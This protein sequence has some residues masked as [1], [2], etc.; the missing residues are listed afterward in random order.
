M[1]KD[2]KHD[3]E[4]LIVDIEKEIE[5][6]SDG[7]ELNNKHW[8]FFKF[9][10]VFSTSTK[11]LIIEP[12]IIE[13]FFIAILDLLEDLETSFADCFE[14]ELYTAIEGL[15]DQVENLSSEIE[16][17]D[18]QLSAMENETKKTLL[19]RIEDLTEKVRQLD[20][21]KEGLDNSVSILKDRVS[22]DRNKIA[23]LEGTIEVKKK[24]IDR[25]VKLINEL[26]STTSKRKIR[27]NGKVRCE[28]K[29]E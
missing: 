17:K 3:Y 24:R 7:I 2:I 20:Y 25:L 8:K 28:I 22:N 19:A 4:Y 12:V 18:K 29:Y 16:E 5:I 27:R 23:N 6:F 26:K 10:K 1:S 9:S 21:I 15:E 11:P 14:A 13:K